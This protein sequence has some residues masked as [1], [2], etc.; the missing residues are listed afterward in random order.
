MQID[1]EEIKLLKEIDPEYVNKLEQKQKREENKKER[2]RIKKLM[3]ELDDC[4]F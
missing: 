3:N 1:E 2:E 4:L